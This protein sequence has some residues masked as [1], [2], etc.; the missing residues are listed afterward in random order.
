MRQRDA[1]E[2]SRFYGIAVTIS[3]GE[4]AAPRFLAT[5]NGDSAAFDIGSLAVLRGSIPPTA[6]EFVVEWAALHQQELREAWERVRRNEPPESIEPLDAEELSEIPQEPR[7]RLLEVEAREGYRIWVRY[8]DGECGEV[9]LSDVTR[10]GVFAAWN[11]RAFFESVHLDEYG[12][13]VWGEDGQLDACPD[14]LYMRLT[15]KT[16]EE[17]MSGL[18]GLS[19]GV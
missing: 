2:I 14:F 6:Q 18:R 17:L 7:R 3:G 15:G 4:V 9:D 19:T 16:V 13:A 5:Y 10:D 12:A 1:V 8:N 11:D